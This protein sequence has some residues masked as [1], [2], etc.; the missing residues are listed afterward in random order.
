MNKKQDT[1]I[2]GFYCDDYSLED[3]LKTIKD[4]G[5]TSEDYKNFKF[6]LDYGGCDDEGGIPTISLNR[7]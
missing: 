4:A 7:D 6:E 5:Y 2:S 1:R 3:I